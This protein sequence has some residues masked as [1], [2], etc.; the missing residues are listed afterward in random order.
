MKQLG[1]LPLNTLPPRIHYEL[2]FQNLP[3]L[4]L[5]KNDLGRPPLP[6]DALLKAFI[7]NGCSPHS[8]TA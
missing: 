4:T 2:L 6:R 3:P 5:G 7:Y 1:L 8:E